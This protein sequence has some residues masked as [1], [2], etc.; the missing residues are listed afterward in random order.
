MLLFWLIFLQILITLQAVGVHHFLMLF[1]FDLLAI[2]SFFFLL[3][4]SE[5]I[6]RY[7]FRPLLYILCFTVIVSNIYTDKEF[8]ARFLSTTEYEQKW[9]ANIYDLSAYINS[10]SDSVDR[11]VCVDWGICNQIYALSQPKNRNKIYDLWALYYT[12]YSRGACEKQ[13]Q[14]LLSNR[15]ALFLMYTNPIFP[16][17]KHNFYSIISQQRG[18]IQ[19]NEMTNGDIHIYEMYRKY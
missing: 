15:S 9:S 13:L 10:V 11:I 12:C 7:I 4:E 1:P 16:E 5:R 8:I 2:L 14:V 19:R 6:W 3:S 17:S 18:A